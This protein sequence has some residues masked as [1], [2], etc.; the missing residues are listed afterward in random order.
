MAAS[1]GAI[2]NVA[3]EGLAPSWRERPPIAVILAAGVGAGLALSFKPH[4]AIGVLCGLAALAAYGR[5]W[6]ILLTPENFIAAAIAAIYVLCTIVFYPS[7]LSAIVPLVRDVYIRVGASLIEMIKTPAVPIWAAAMFAALVVKRAGRIDSMF[8]LLLAT[9]FGFM[10]AFFLQRKGWPYHSYPMIALA[11]LGLGYALAMRTPLD[12]AP[13][14]FAAATL[15][16]VFVQSILWFNWAFDKAFDARP[17]EASIARLGPHPKILAITGEPGLG[18]P[19][20]RA[21]QGGAAREE[22]Q[23]SAAALI[24]SYLPEYLPELA[25]EAGRIHSFAG[26]AGTAHYPPF[27][28]RRG[29]RRGLGWDFSC[30]PG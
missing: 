13:G 17:L 9:S 19:L 18:H 8:L 29:R 16:V 4:F 25:K 28:S 6:R 5:S 24:D 12:R 27:P 2:A 10:L 7:Y 14:I 21:L 22:S 26:Y 20:T 11:T 3:G 23:R 30:I 1:R 15:T